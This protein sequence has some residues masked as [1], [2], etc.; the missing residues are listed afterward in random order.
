MWKPGKGRIG[1]QYQNH[2]SGG[3]NQIIERSLGKNCGRQLREHGFVFHRQDVEV[4]CKV[5]DTNE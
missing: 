3:L 5:G 2:G 4:I 1:R